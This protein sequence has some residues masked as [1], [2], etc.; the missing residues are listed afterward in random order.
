MDR[1]VTIPPAL[2]RIERH[3]LHLREAFTDGS[4][5]EDRM[6]AAALLPDGRLSR[7]VPG[8]GCSMRAELYALE[9]AAMAAATGTTILTDSLSAIVSL[10][11]GKAPWVVGRCSIGC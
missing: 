8:I 6:S 2:P 3:E 7:R 10:S 11:N 9:L 4:L 1:F 5:W